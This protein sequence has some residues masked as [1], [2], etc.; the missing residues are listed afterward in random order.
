[1]ISPLPRRQWLKTESI[2]ITGRPVTSL[3]DDNE[4]ATLTDIR[5][6]ISEGGSN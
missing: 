6:G 5:D 3:K 2:S 1:M 4:T